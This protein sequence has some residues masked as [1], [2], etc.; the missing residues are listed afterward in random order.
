[1]T[2]LKDFEAYLVTLKLDDSGRRIHSISDGDGPSGPGAPQGPNGNREIVTDER[3]VV[4]PWKMVAR[5]GKNVTLK[6]AVEEIRKGGGR[7]E[8]RLASKFEVEHR[9]EIDKILGLI[10]YIDK[11]Y[12]EEKFPEIYKFGPERL[13]IHFKDKLVL[14]EYSSGYPINLGYDQLDYFKKTIKAYQGRDEDAVKYVKKVKELIDKPLDEMIEL[15]DVRLAMKKIKC[16]RKLD[17]SA[18]YQLTRR[19]PHEDLNY[20]DERLLLHHFYDTFCNESIKLLGKTVRYRVNV[21]YHLLA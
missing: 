5:Y 13:G 4:M 7:G 2:T 21:L 18:F 14:E 17:I 12:V 20:D 8:R 1:M 10:D 16:P 3:Y 6:E 19:L 15:E 11:G 9:D